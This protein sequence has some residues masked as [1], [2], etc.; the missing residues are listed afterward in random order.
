M[1]REAVRFGKVTP[2]PG[3]PSIDNLVVHYTLV[4]IATPMGLTGLVLMV[5]DRL[6]GGHGGKKGGT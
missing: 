4:F 2:T 6:L 3:K 5:E 1:T